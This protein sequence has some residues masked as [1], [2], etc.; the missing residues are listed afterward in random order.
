MRIRFIALP[1][2]LVCLFS[3]VTPAFSA[4]APLAP[5]DL[6]ADTD[7][8]SVILT[9]SPPVDTSVS[10]F[11]V[12]RKDD[13]AGRE[14]ARINR[15]LVSASN[16]TDR[17]V[18]SGKSY[19]YICKSV[20]SDGVESDG[21]NIAGAPKMQMTASAKVSHMGKTV[22]IAAPGDIINYSIDFANRGFGIAKNVVI[23]YAIPKG[24]TFI[25]GTAKCPQYKVNISYFDT[26]SGQWIK[27]VKNEENVS[28]VRF[29][30]LEDVA[31]VANGQSDYAMLKVLV[32]Y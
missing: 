15:A 26:V 30:V 29:E 9:W 27:T 14:F 7:G 6:G 16:Y 18:Q 10:G 1:L 23:V 22:R 3:L 12:Y 28:K 4:T 32:N 21:S 5:K 17:D 13:M 19:T 2:V 24:T 11:N 20:N 25:S 31:P 8:S